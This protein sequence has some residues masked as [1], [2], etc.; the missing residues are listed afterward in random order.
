MSDVGVC[1]TITKIQNPYKLPPMAS[2]SYNEPKARNV[3][4]DVSAG[5]GFIAPPSGIGKPDLANMEQMDMYQQ[6]KCLASRDI[7]E[8]RKKSK[9][10]NDVPM[11]TGVKIIFGLAAATIAG[12]ALKKY[13]AFEKIANIFKRP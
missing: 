3:E 7:V 11:P 4:K 5:L 1:M 6:A 8:Q 12:L 2:F 9:N 10:K 13:G